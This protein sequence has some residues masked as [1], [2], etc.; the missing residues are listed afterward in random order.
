[1]SNA[2][3]KEYLSYYLVEKDLNLETSFF[4]EDILVQASY[5]T[6][7]DYSIF[8][9]T[10]SP[11]GTEKGFVAGINSVDWSDFLCSGDFDGDGTA[12]MAM[13]NGSGVVKIWGV[14]DGRLVSDTVLSAVDPAS[15][16]FAGVGDFNGDGTDDIAWCNESTGLAGCWEIS[17]KALSAWSNIATIA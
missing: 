8:Y 3:A 17:N 10:D 7:Y 9:I 16:T 6:I 11:S 15:W 5:P 13:I 12:D 4:E 14:S 1:M 2:N